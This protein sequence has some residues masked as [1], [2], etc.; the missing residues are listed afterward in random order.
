MSMTSRVVAEFD[1]GEPDAASGHLR[2][3]R[4]G[5]QADREHELDDLLVGE[6][7][8]LLVGDQPLLARLAPHRRRIDPAPVVAHL[9]HDLLALMERSH[10]DLGL[11]GLAGGPAGLRRLDA[12]I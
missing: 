11:L 12:V 5:R 1:R 7:T 8:R 10:G 6:L 3:L 4:A 2:H 9:D